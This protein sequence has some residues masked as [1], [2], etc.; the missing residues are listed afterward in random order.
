MGDNSHL[1]SLLG[2][3]PMNVM[4]LSKYRTMFRMIL[5]NMLLTLEYYFFVETLTKSQSIGLLYVFIAAV[6][7]WVV[8]PSEQ[9]RDSLSKREHVFAVG[10]GVFPFLSVTLLVAGIDNTKE[11]V[12]QLGGACLALTIIFY[13]LYYNEMKLEL[14]NGDVHGDGSIN[15]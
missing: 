11:L 7:S 14:E 10:C 12:V 9:A 5:G 1:S 2:H 3:E 13:A 8:Y 4:L 15:P 6:M